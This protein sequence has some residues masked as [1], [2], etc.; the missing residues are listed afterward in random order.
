VHISA[1][2]PDDSSRSRESI[3]LNEG[4]GQQFLAAFNEGWRDAACQP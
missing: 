2:R 3:R 1:G 4:D